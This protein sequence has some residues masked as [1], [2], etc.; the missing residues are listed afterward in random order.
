MKQQ[1]SMY[2]VMIDYGN[3]GQEAI[4]DPE[5]TRRGVIDRIASGEYRNISYILHVQTGEI[6]EDLTEELIEEAKILRREICGEEF[7]A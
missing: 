6:P 5:I 7:A 2:V 3:R 4:V 1:H